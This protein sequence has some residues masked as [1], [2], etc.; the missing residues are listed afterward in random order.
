MLC[1]SLIELVDVIQQVHDHNHLVFCVVLNKR[2]RL[3]LKKISQISLFIFL[4]EKKR[5][6]GQ[7][8]LMVKFLVV[9]IY[10]YIV[11]FDPYC[12]MNDSKKYESDSGTRKETR[13][14]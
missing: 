14:D 8:V 12:K 11:P 13:W 10:N 3:M 6:L 5:D 4:K 9:L 2:A 7:N 1:V